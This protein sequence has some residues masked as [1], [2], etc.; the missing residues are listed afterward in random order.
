[1]TGSLVNLTAAMA[2]SRA[3]RWRGVSL[4][5]RGRTEA[6]GKAS[7][8]V[9]ST[10][11]FYGGSASVLAVGWA[12]RPA[13]KGRR[14]CELPGTRFRVRV[15]VVSEE[16]KHSHALIA[17]TGEVQGGSSQIRGFVDVQP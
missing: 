13:V 5:R 14:C 3:A 10:A 16:K 4:Q 12:Q 9:L 8:P 1:M 7:A 11:E 17:R 6:F 15:G 2:S